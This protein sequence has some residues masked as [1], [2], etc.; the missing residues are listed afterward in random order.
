MDGPLSFLGQTSSISWHRT[1]KHL[2]AHDRVAWLTTGS[3]AGSRQAHVA[4]YVAH[5][6]TDHM[7]AHP[8]LATVAAEALLASRTGARRACRPGT[9][10]WYVAVE[11]DASSAAEPRRREG[12]ALLG[13]VR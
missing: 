9:L 5:H 12:I 13:L 7:W 11:P 4:A 8:G 10:G 6:L 2:L 1:V 3:S